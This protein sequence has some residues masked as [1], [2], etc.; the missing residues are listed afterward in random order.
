MRRNFKKYFRL[1]ALMLSCGF[2][3]PLLGY[4]FALPN[5]RY[6]HPFQEVFLEYFR[7]FW[8]TLSSMNL[9]VTCVILF[10][11]I[12]LSHN[13]ISVH[14]RSSAILLAGY[15]LAVCNPLFFYLF[16]PVHSP[17]AF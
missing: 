5:S 16:N 3:W 7:Y 11:L 10:Y 2:A 4:L 1:L 8:E 12:L 14:R 17:H 15:I 13:F 6:T 9:F